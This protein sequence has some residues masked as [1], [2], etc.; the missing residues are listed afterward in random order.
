MAFFSLNILWSKLAAPN[1]WF[2]LALQVRQANTKST[3]IYVYI[4]YYITIY[5]VIVYVKN[6]WVYP[7][8][9]ENMRTKDILSSSGSKLIVIVWSIWCKKSGQWPQSVPASFHWG[10]SWQGRQ[11]HHRVHCLRGIIRKPGTGRRNAASLTKALPHFCKSHRCTCL[12]Q[13]EKNRM[14]RVS[15][16]IIGWQ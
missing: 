16:E 10:W 12:V 14:A 1:H 11:G 2:F 6:A 5:L 13:L 3:N 9:C 15:T 7:Y 8:M 4:I